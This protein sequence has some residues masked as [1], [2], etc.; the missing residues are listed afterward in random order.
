MS[1][2]LLSRI[3]AADARTRVISFRRN[4]GQTAAMAAGIRASRGEIL[5]PMDADLQNDPADIPRFVARIQEGADL[6]SGW[7]AERHGLGIARRMGSLVV[8]W[9]IT[10]STGVRLRDH[11]CGFKAMTHRVA[12]EISRYGHLRAF[13]PLLLL[14]LARSVAEVPVADHPRRHGRSKYTVTQLLAL[15]LEFVIASSTRPFRV[16]GFGGMLGVLGG[17]AAALAYLSGRAVFGMPASD[18]ILVAILLLTFAGSQFTI[19]GLLGEYA[20]RAYHAAQALP[21]YVVEDEL[22]RSR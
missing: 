7:R 1:L 10:A 22:D 19:L 9:L 18:R 15:T 20:V 2:Q 3:A 11:N 17:L 8:D 12:R 6:V 14:T 13:L 21:F 4:Y 5:I 16:I